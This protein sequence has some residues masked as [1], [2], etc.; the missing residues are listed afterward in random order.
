MVYDVVQAFLSMFTGLITALVRMILAI[1]MAVI[2]LPRLDRS[3]MP[4]WVSRYLNLDSGG[5][6]AVLLLFL[7]PMLVVWGLIWY[8][9]ILL[10]V[11]LAIYHSCHYPNVH[12]AAVP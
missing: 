11:C 7:G 4:A 8:H 6:C 9:A 10:C 12:F 3:A 1:A 5:A 2:T